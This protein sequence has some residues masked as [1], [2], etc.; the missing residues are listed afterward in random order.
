MRVS[1][2]QSIAAVAHSGNCCQRYYRFRFGFFVF[3]LVLVNEFTIFSFLPIF[4]LVF[5]NEIT[6]QDTLLRLS[7]QPEERLALTLRWLATDMPS[8]IASV[9]KIR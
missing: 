1:G 3:V 2:A 5:V 6:L 8:Y 7:V 9:V 4:V